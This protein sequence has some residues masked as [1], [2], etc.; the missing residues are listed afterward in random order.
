MKRTVAICVLAAGT[1]CALVLLFLRMNE[2]PPRRPLTE[3]E[4]E[5]VMRYVPQ[6]IDERTV[7]EIVMSRAVL[8]KEQVSPDGTYTV[9][10][11]SLEQYEDILPLCRTVENVTTSTKENSVSVNYLAM[12]G[13]TIWVNYID[14][15]LASVSVHDEA[16]DFL[17]IYELYSG[18]SVCYPKFSVQFQD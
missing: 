17:W 2:I 9:R 16:Q 8:E 10:G 3:D 15:I 6:R 1:L 18:E 4:R 7:S 14:G 12:D 5:E 13:R 11:Y